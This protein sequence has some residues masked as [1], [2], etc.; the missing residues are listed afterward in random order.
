MDGHYS[1]ALAASLVNWAV[2]RTPDPP[3]DLPMDAIGDVTALHC[4]AQVP[5]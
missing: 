2:S 1:D 5:F 3:L 4:A